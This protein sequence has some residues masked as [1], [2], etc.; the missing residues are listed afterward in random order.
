MKFN[1]IAG[2]CFISIL[3][4]SWYKISNTPVASVQI[5]PV[6]EQPKDPSKPWCYKHNTQNGFV[7]VCG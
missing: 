4:Y 6:G 3:G 7:I 5:V 1:I 2:I